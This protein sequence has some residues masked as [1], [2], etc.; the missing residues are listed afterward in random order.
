MEELTPKQKITL[1]KIRNLL[2]H[3]SKPITLEDLKKSLGYTSKNV[4]SVQR[5]T[6]ALK[7]KGYLEKIR[8]IAIRN[9]SNMVQIPVVG[10]V[11]CGQPLLAIENIDAYIP[12]DASKINGRVSDYF[13]LK[14]SGNSMNNTDINGKTIDDGDYILVKKQLN[15]V[16]GNRVVALIGD[17]A[18]TKLLK[19]GE[20]CL[21]LQPES[22]DPNNKPIYLFNDVQI[23][24]IVVDVV[25]KRKLN[26]V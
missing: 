12:F 8:G 13:F 6:D 22:T 23:Q 2:A 15:T 25:K 3:G 17:E 24:G 18:T 20:D 16:S 14:A 11:S 21:I 10:N 4:S 5:H 26:H 1:Q 9:Y 19:K 7:E